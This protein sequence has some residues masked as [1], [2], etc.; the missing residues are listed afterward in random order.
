M[1]QPR[2]DL[3]WAS[4]SSAEPSHA[5][6]AEL[7][8]ASS[9]FMQAHICGDRAGMAAGGLAQHVVA[10]AALADVGRAGVDGHHQIRRGIKDQARFAAERDPACGDFRNEEGLLLQAE[11]C[12]ALNF[13]I[14]MSYIR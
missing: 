4:R 10:L 5:V 8:L 3:S 2:E 11:G 14:L 6:S 12:T 13:P 1:P 7:M 9:T